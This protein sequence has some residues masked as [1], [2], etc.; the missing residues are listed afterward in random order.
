MFLWAALLAAAA[1]AA[2]VSPGP[3]ISE[4]LANDRAG[5]ISALRYELSLRIPEKKAEAIRGSEVIRFTLR[6]PHAMSSTSSSPAI[7]CA[8]FA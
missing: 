7:M 3:G 4:G 8:Q 1:S 5:T 6:A 2:A